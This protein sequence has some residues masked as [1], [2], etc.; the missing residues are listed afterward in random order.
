MVEWRDE[1]ILIGV[2][3]LGESAAMIETLTATHGRHAGVVKGGAS[4]RM[5]PILQPGAQLALH[6]TARLETHLGTFRVEPVRSRSAI[7]GDSAALAALGAVVSLVSA[8]LPE[9]A[10][11]PALY[12]ATV[13]LLDLME[14]GGDWMSA[15]AR[16]ELALLADL[17][18]GIDLG[19]CAVTGAS[20]GLAFVSPRTG[21]AVTREGAGEWES[22]LLPLPEFLLAPGSP[23]NGPALAEA[24]DLTGYFLER[25]LAPTLM[26]ET[27][28]PARSRAVAAILARHHAR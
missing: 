11:H 22:R 23:A 8:A 13:A 18:F 27:L 10:P 26:R 14:E 19:A 4:R 16:W 1:G 20:E 17:G 3:R 25:R 12:A 5:A 9:R 6:W 21:R 24:L 2:R 15:Y 28:P 7:M